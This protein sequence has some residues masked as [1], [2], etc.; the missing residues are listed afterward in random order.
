MQR[1]WF[2]CF[3]F[4]LFFNLQIIHVVGLFLE[5]NCTQVQLKELSNQTDKNF[6]FIS[7]YSAALDYNHG[8]WL[9]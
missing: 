5:E 9:A 4:V 8:E 1:Y 3:C 6:S 7:V 2:V